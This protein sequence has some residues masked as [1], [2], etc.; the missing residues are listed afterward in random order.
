MVA[1][2]FADFECGFRHVHREM[3]SAL[4]SL[5]RLVELRKTRTLGERHDGVII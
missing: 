5:P 2:G 1:G 4:A 3:A